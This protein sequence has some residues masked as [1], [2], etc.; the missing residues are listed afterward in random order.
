M[1]AH[2][3]A[4]LMMPA[5]NTLLFLAGLLP[6]ELYIALNASTP[7]AAATLHAITHLRRERRSL[8]QAQAE[9][10]A[11]CTHQMRG[12]IEGRIAAGEP[13]SRIAEEHGLEEEAL[14]SHFAFHVPRRSGASG[15][16]GE[17]DVE[18]E[19][20]KML[21]ELKAMQERLRG[22]DSLFESGEVRVQDYIR[23][24]AERRA[25]T[26]EIRALLLLVAKTS[27]KSNVGRDIGALLRKLQNL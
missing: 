16:S 20:S 24:L 18:A 11:V 2:T 19:L 17:I 14:A 13:L 12:A 25:L 22:L 6:L 8:G 5:I 23:L 3:A 26:R 27:P 1:K 9:A 4:A 10:C 7:P 21:E 15:S